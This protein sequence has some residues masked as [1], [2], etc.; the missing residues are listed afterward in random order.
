MEALRPLLLV[1]E[2][3]VGLRTMLG[4]ALKDAGYAAGLAENGQQALACMVEAMR[5]LTLLDLW[6]PVMDGWQIAQELCGADGQ[7]IPLVVL[8]AMPDGIT[9]AMPLGLRAMLRKPFDLEA[10][11]A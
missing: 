6:V 8:T 5:G 9:P 2:D 3:E 4:L 10:L 11:F 7:P 1:I